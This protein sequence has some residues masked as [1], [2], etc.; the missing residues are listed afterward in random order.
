MGLAIILPLGKNPQACQCQHKASCHY[1]YFR[2]SSG[3]Q[4]WNKHIT[5]ANR[6]HA[7]HASGILALADSSRRRH[8]GCLTCIWMA[9]SPSCHAG[10]ACQ[11]YAL[12]NIVCK[13][14]CRIEPSLSPTHAFQSTSDVWIQATEISPPE[15][16]VFSHDDV[17][18]FSRAEV[19]ELPT[20]QAPSIDRVERSVRLSML[21]SIYHPFNVPNRHR[22]HTSSARGQYTVCGYLHWCK[23]T[24]SGTY[25][26]TYRLHGRWMTQPASHRQ[27]FTLLLWPN[28]FEFTISSGTYPVIAPD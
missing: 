13:Y 24:K 5:T 4:T 3:G 8:P 23:T 28:T 2:N 7:S 6:T 19:K 1:A 17:K 12:G 20:A 11:R 15:Q 27:Q 21:P 9:F 10:P 26:Q 14:D 18:S 16:H 25:S 22:A